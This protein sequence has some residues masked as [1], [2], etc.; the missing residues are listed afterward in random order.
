MVSLFFPNSRSTER[1]ADDL[2][3]A[4]DST[5]GIRDPGFQLTKTNAELFAGAKR[6]MSNPN[7]G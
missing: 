5:N 6:A 4:A 1:T 2:V 3:Q 7:C